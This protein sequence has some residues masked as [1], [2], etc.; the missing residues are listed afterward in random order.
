MA[1]NQVLNCQTGKLTDSALSELCLRKAVRHTEMEQDIE[2]F[3]AIM[4]LLGVRV[5]LYIG[6]AC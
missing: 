5:K 3:E 4:S 1:S 6:T 2:V